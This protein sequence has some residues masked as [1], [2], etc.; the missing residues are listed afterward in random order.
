MSF[1]VVLYIEAIR[2][3]D[4][5]RGWSISWK[6]KKGRKY[7]YRQINHNNKRDEVYVRRRDEKAVLAEF[8]EKKHWTKIKQNLTADLKALPAAERREIHQQMKLYDELALDKLPDNKNVALDGVTMDSREEIVAYDLLNQAGISSKH[9]K[10]L[11][12]DPYSYRP[13][14]IFKIVNK[15]FYYE[16]MGKIQDPD[17]HRSQIRKI[18]NY[19]N[20]LDPIT[21]GDNLIITAPHNGFLQVPRMLWRLVRAGAIPARKARRMRM[22]LR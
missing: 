16:H 1:N 2:Q 12:D 14:F 6:T 19:A 7:L 21:Y 4:D 3:V 8:D 22:N 15:T 17:Y 9:D 18:R 11:D 13:D 5:R 20:R 10:A